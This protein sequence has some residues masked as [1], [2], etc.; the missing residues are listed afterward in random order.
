MK[1]DVDKKQLAEFQLRNLRI[2]AHLMEHD[3][4]TDEM[5]EYL[6]QS[7][8]DYFSLVEKNKLL[9]EKIHIDEK[10]NLLKFNNKYLTNIVKTASRVFEGMKSINYNVTFIRFDID[11]FSVVNNKYGHE[12]GDEVLTKI[13]QILKDNSR[14]TDYV[15]RFGGEEFDIILPSTH[16]GKATT[17]LKKIYDRI[18]NSRFHVQKEKLLITISGGVSSFIFQFG[19]SIQIDNIEI[20]DSFKKLQSEADDALYEAKYLGKNRYCI[21]SKEKEG[22]YPKIRE[23]Y[24]KKR[25]LLE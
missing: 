25:L 8:L 3:A 24:L 2:L 17:Y 16:I 9:E 6:W 19:D 14:P 13:A 1:K 20:E 15:I 12:F 18:N 4:V 22:D 5:I 23:Q 21:Y 11:D 7:E 10:T